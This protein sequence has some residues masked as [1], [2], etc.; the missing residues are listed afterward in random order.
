VAKTAFQDSVLP[1]TIVTAAFLNGLQNLIPDGANADGHGP[2]NYSVDTGAANAYVVA[3]SPAFPALVAGISIIFQAANANTGA[4]TLNVNGLGAVA[5]KKIV[6]QALVAGDILAGEVVEVIY[7]GTYF[8]L[9]SPSEIILA[10]SYG[11]NGYKVWADKSTPSKV[12]IA[13]WGSVYVAANS[14]TVFSFPLAFTQILQF[15]VATN[16]DIATQSVAIVASVYQYGGY[17]TNTEGAISF[18]DPGGTG[19]TQSWIATGY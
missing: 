2:V 17:P 11:S 3:P 6:N 18:W 19:T 1:G 12:W 10:S 16:I 7:D 9:V 5:I 14:S 4:S 15:L 13:E 8:Q